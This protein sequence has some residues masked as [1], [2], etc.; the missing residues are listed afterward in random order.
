M[1]EL[2]RHLNEMGVIARPAARHEPPPPAPR[3][4]PRRAPGV[5]FPDGNVTF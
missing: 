3:P 4:D 5:W 1:T 2:E